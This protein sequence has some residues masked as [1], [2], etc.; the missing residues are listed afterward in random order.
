MDETILRTLT[1]PELRTLRQDIEAT[2][3]AKLR[4][5]RLAKDPAQSQPGDGPGEAGKQQATANVSLLDLERERDAWIAS[6]KA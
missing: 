1:L 3:R 2:I 4:A 6:R 5:Q